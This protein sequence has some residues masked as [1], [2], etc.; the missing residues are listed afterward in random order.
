MTNDK[1]GYPIPD[2]Y[3]IVRTS[4]EKP[5]NTWR[6]DIYEE[7]IY[8]ILD[9]IEELFPNDNKLQG[10]ATISL[11]SMFISRMLQ[12]EILNHRDGKIAPHYRYV[13]NKSIDL[14]DAL[15]T[16]IKVLNDSNKDTARYLMEHPKLI[17]DEER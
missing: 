15:L 8:K 12:K 3:S 7:N 11:P 13:L 5:S 10:S 14:V 16:C 9:Y 1:Y 6:D 17:E 4:T 2:P